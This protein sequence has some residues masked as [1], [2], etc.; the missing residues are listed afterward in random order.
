MV[1]GLVATRKTAGD[2]K[3]FFI[4]GADIS[5]T[6]MLADGVHLSESG[7]SQL[8]DELIGLI[9]PSTVSTPGFFAANDANFQYSGRIDFTNPR[10]PA[11]AFPGVSVKTKFSGSSL[12]VVIIVF[13]SAYSC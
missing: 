3:I 9:E 4:N 1:S 11:F 5:N 13:Y 12:S 8:A 2:N 6:S 7:A 10:R